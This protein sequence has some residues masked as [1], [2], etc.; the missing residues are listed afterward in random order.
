MDE[1]KISV[2]YARALLDSAKEK[3][4]TEAVKADMETIAQLFVAI[5][6]FAHLL[7]SP[8]I[9]LNEKRLL[10]E[11]VFFKN[12]NSLTYSFLMML[13]TNSREAYLQAITRNFLTSLRKETGYKEA[14]LISAIP[15]D[16]NTVKKF[17]ELIKKHFETNVDLSC[18]VNPNLIGGFVLQVEDQQIDASVATRLKKLKKEL[19]TSQS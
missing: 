17:E 5:P 11:N 1:S 8:V 12:L 2:R 7:E 18:T 9:R 3:K 14:K 10:F 19:L 15:V 4:V 16:Q 13:I 6:G